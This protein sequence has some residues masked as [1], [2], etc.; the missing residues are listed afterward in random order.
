MQR[1]TL[2]LVLGPAAAMLLAAPG[3]AEEP[4]GRV[5]SVA[6]DATAQ[7]PGE[8]PRPLACDDPIYAGDVLRT[9]GSS[10]VGVLS[11]DVM[12]ELAADSQLH[13]SRTDRGMPAATL[14]RGRVRVLDSRVA[15]AP[16]SL[17]A[18]DVRAEVVG[19]DAEAY[20]FEEKVGPYAML[21]DWDAG[22]PV[23]RGDE[24]QLA[25]PRECVIAK[26]GEPLY[27][28]RAHE[29][30]I[31]IAAAEECGVDPN[32]L[33]AR[34]GDPLHHLSPADVA[35]PPPLA[36]ISR[37]AR[38]DPITSHRQ[39]CDNPGSCNAGFRAVANSGP[40]QTPNP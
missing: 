7:R 31:P 17:A 32:L 22:L 10:R 34:A 16:A 9:G 36:G 4:L 8:R 11:G 37:P 28:A 23:A 14:E 35:A 21:C 5:S 1:R 6:G 30:R 26:P 13:V 27:T 19:A 3:F 33:A 12:T 24:R 40:P 18:L 25:A 15:G 39:P 20:I 38:P 29:A 2:L